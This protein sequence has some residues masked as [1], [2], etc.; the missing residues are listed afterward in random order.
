VYIV[1]GVAIVF[2]FEG[3]EG[4]CSSSHL[5]LCSRPSLVTVLICSR[6]FFSTNARSRSSSHRENARSTYDLSVCGQG[7]AGLE[8]GLDDEGVDTGATAAAGATVL[9]AVVADVAV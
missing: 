8:A 4:G 6:S 1:V 5:C 2:C 7:E 9:G 3:G